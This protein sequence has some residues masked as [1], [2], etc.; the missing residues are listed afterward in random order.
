MQRHSI[1]R[2]L[3][4]TVVL[5]QSLLALGLLLAGVYYTHV[6]LLSALDETVQARAMSVAALVR[7][8]EDATGNVYF[9]N[10]LMPPSIDPKRPDLFAVW[11]NRT[12]LVAH[13]SNWPGATIEEAPDGREQWDFKLGNI[14]YR[15]VRRVNVPIL[16]R[17]EGNSFAPQTLTVLYASPTIRIQEQVRQIAIFIGVASL[18]LLFL[19]VML[20]LWGIRR[21][22]S[23]LRTL[24]G[25]AALISSNNWKLQ[26]S[27]DVDEVAELRPVSESMVTMLAR[28]QRSFEQQREFIGNAAH[29]LKTPVAVL[30]STL[31]SLL[32][33][34]RSTEEYRSGLANSLEDL[35]RLEELLQRMLHLARAEQRDTAAPRRNVQEV[36]VRM[37]CQAAL[38][39]I[40]ALADTR[41]TR[42][43]LSANGPMLVSGDPEDL[44]L[45][46]TNLLENAI[47]YSPEGTPIEFIL[48]R[49]GDACAEVVV[50]DH[51]TGI[52]P[53]DL[54]YIF[55]R[56]YRGDPSRTRGTG[57]FGLGL[58][59]AKALIE[60][61]AGKI[62]A[63]SVP[64]K[65]TRITVNLPLAPA[66][67][68]GSGK[69]HGTVIF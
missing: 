42:I 11:A 43:S 3:I 44:Q 16:D 51:G 34:P 49:V 4:T 63:E 40:R 66:D 35:E 23:P 6:R 46:W 52:A 38:E 28:L 31:Q 56:F 57:G 65:G 41:G 53:A 37:T 29:E 2:R 68:N 25:E 36:D 21:G 19:A 7:Y 50:Q 55:D 18:A 8:T 1:K 10:T 67:S 27:K 20:A 62:A 13:S 15:A 61:N 32:H 5:S 26:V 30:K 33:R 24:A 14:P 59:I 69:P 48:S 12:G 64:G 54:P 58:A 47:R 9:D 39:R 60:A 45:V 22:L 17:E